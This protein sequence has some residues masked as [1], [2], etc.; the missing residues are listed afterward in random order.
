MEGKL[1]PVF[2]MHER[3]A[4]HR[5]VRLL[6]GPLRG[7]AVHDD[8]AA[9][10]EL[11]N[12]GFAYLEALPRWRRVNGFNRGVAIDDVP[13]PRVRG[14]S[15]AVHHPYHRAAASDQV[16][17]HLKTRLEIRVA[18]TLRASPAVMSVRAR[19]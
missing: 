5:R 7:D 19:R 13:T 16:P 1:G 2:T 8:A 15:V 4:D 3:A 6:A 17:S 9:V 18:V 12:S 10:I 14:R 11:D